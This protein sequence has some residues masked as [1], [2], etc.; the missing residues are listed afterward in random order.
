MTDKKCFDTATREEDDDDPTENCDDDRMR[1]GGVGAGGGEG[2]RGGGVLESSHTFQASKN[3]T[4]RQLRHCATDRRI[5][6][7]FRRC[8]A[9]PTRQASKLRDTAYSLI[10]EAT[11]AARHKSAVWCIHERNAARR[12]W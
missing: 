10:R 2:S 11:L 1:E 6:S 3:S 4:N 7:R 9:A 5:I 8:C 12:D